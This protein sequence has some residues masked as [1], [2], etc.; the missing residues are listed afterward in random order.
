MGVSPRVEAVN[1]L[2]FVLSRES[3]FIGPTVD[4][5]GSVSRNVKA[6]H[7]RGLT[8]HRLAFEWEVF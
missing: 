7:T 4:L 8:P 5:V 6:V 2:F 3:G 1:G